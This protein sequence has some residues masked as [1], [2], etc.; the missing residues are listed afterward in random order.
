MSVKTLRKQ[1]FAAIAMVLVAAIALGSSTYAWFASNTKVDA[2]GATVTATTVKALLIDTA[3]FTGYSTVAMEAD[4]SPASAMWPVT[5]TK[6][7]V[8]HVLTF[9][10]LT[11]DQMKNVASNGTTSETAST[12]TTVDYFHDTVYLKLDGEGTDTSEIIKVTPTMTYT[13][14]GSAKDI[15]KSVHVAVYDV[16]ADNFIEFDMGAQTL[17]TAAASQDLTTLEYNAVAKQYEVYMWIDGPDTDCFNANT[18]SLQSFSCN[19][20]FEIK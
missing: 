7:A 9:N 16:T 12:A 6:D 17:G 11:A 13:G 8:N 20:A 5:D 1:L 18:G 14:S 2:T 15:Y 10:K 4:N 3:S 19:L